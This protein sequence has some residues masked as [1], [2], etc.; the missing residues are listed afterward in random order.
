MHLAT[1]R[2]DMHLLLHN[3]SLEACLVALLKSFMILPQ[4]NFVMHVTLRNNQSII[5]L[6]NL[7][8]HFPV[9]DSDPIGLGCHCPRWTYMYV[10]K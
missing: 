8:F 2:Y 6:F 10:S 5:E 3:P 1:H 9:N 7:C 4:T